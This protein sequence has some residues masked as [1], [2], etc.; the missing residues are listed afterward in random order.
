MTNH[1]PTPYPDVNEVLNLLLSEARSVLD[2]QFV[3]MYLY[4][5][6]ASGDFNPESSDIDFLVV[7]AG[8]LDERTIARLE[9]MHQRLWDSGLKWTTKLEG[10]YLPRRHLPRYKKTGIAYPTV[11]E[12][13]FFVAPHDSDWIIQ[14]HIIREHGVTLAGPDPQSLID[15][16]SPGAIRGAVLGYL[17]GWWFPLLKELTCLKSRGSAYHA[18]AIL[19]MCRSL[20]AL[21]HGTIVSKSAAAKWAQL[22]FGGQW[23]LAIERALSMQ[24]AK[25]GFDLFDEAAAFIQFALER[26]GAN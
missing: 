12:G 21:E 3:G 11:N 25:E 9:A 22:K 18:Y 6:L 23:Q 1:A 16:V 2:E 17:R 8:M 15:P 19:S 4:G 13:A 20:Y 14:R 10:S 24:V 5:S 26:V 7:T